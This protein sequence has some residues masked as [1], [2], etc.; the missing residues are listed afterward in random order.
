MSA[1]ECKEANFCTIRGVVSLVESDGVAMG[2][3]SQGEGRCVTLSLSGNDIRYLRGTGP[4]EATV[5]GKIY[6]GHHD[7]NSILLK[8]E[9][10]DVSY[11]RCGEFYLFVP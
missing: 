6:R 1:D 8:I 9:G 3:I 7:P 5:S 4:I 10:R 2:E 11:P